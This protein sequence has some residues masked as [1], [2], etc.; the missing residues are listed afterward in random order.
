MSIEMAERYWQEEIETM[1]LEDMKKLQSERLIA[2]VKHVYDN[3]E[4][5]RK[6]MDEKG[7]KPEDIK[8]IEDLSKLPFVTKDDLRDC[9]PYGMLAVPIGDCVRGLLWLR[10]VYGRSGS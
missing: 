1:A 2:Q 4:L 8:S 6:R 9:Y 5:Y 3:V 7:V 10:S